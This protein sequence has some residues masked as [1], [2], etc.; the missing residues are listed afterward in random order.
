MAVLREGPAA[1]AGRVLDVSDGRDSDRQKES[2]R[3]LDRVSR[4][5]DSGGFTTLGTAVESVR[6]RVEAETPRDVDA[7]DYWGTR[8]GRALGLVI[9]VAIILWLAAYIFG[10]L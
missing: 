6:R 2:R 9:T 5:A 3:I 10:G 8:I 4:E 1:A 7:I